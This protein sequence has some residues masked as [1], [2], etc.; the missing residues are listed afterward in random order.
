MP[1]KK[2]KKEVIDEFIAAH[3][4]FYDYS[5]VEYVN[6]N[7]K[8]IIICPKHGEFRITPN[9]HKNGVGCRKCYDDS[10]KITKE[11]FVRR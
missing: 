11:E 4:N 3:G 10:Q 2:P 5:L 6:T 8:V 9:H 7:S 1:R